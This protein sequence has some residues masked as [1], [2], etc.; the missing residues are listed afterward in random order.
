MAPTVDSPKV[1][2]GQDRGLITSFDFQVTGIVIACSTQS[3]SFSFVP[4]E[5]LKEFNIRETGLI[6]HF[7]DIFSKRVVGHTQKLPDS[8]AGSALLVVASSLLALLRTP[9]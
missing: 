6:G 5:T 8:S 3:P 2:A 1:R 7:G 9:T 4:S